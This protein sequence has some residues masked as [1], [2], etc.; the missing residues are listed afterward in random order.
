MLS[1]FCNSNSEYLKDE[2]KSVIETLNFQT[3]FDI[4]GENKIDDG[5]HV[6]IKCM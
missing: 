5:F 1:G 6:N 4:H 2:F 3:L